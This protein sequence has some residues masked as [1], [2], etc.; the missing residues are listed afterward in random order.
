MPVE[1]IVES[2]MED[3][4]LKEKKKAAE[5][6]KRDIKK[7]RAKEFVELKFQV[8]ELKRKIRIL[9][10]E[11]DAACKRL[12]EERKTSQTKLG[13]EQ[14]RMKSQL[15]AKDK[16]LNELQVEV[17]DL[18]KNVEVL[19]GKL[20]TAEQMHS[21]VVD[22]LNSCQAKLVKAENELRR[23]EEEHISLVQ[24]M[25]ETRELL[26]KEQKAHFDEST[27]NLRLTQ[28][29]TLRNHDVLKLKD[30]IH[31]LR[32]KLKKAKRVGRILVKV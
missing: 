5:S 2:V 4:M 18:Q 6:E 30:T 8:S 7:D 29:L 13:E 22:E 11:R 15:K 25:E 12:E 23:V 9:E 28:Q 1:K 16:E 19:A 20:Q 10:A 26:G 3:K 27:E 21:K 14:E 24:Q 32:E 31:E 17:Y